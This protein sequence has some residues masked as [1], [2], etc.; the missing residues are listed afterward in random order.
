MPVV[1]KHIFVSG[2]TAFHI[3]WY[4]WSILDSSRVGS[5]KCSSRK[6]FNLALFSVE[7]DMFAEIRVSHKFFWKFYI[8]L[9]FVD[10]VSCSKRC[11]D[12][13]LLASYIA[14]MCF[15]R[16]TCCWTMNFFTTATFV[17]Q[18]LQNSILPSVDKMSYPNS[19]TIAFK[20][21]GVD[22]F[23]L[24]LNKQTDIEQQGFFSKIFMQLKQRQ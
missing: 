19:D 15:S 21:H 20:W 22:G 5:L 4:N 18:I 1:R 10:A 16:P 8:L 14:R 12:L 23:D 3:R 11:V 2:E 24:W 7:N 13:F 9:S 17:S 6:L